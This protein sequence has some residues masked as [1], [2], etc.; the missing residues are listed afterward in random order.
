MT[1]IGNKE[2]EGTVGE[3]ELSHWK[4]VGRLQPRLREKGSRGQGE[5][6]HSVESRKTQCGG[7]KYVRGLENDRTGSKSGKI[8]KKIPQTKACYHKTASKY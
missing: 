7:S 4:V 8:M 6:A 2:A 1:G 3:G 5:R